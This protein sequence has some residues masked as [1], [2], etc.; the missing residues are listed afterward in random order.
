MATDE[1]KTAYREALADW[2]GK[3]TAIH[4]LLLDGER[5]GRRPDEIKGLLNREARAKEKYDEAR[6]RLLGIG[7]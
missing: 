3:L 2:Q 5:D 6:L 7:D 4:R 1:D